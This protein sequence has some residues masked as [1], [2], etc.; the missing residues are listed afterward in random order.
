M[1]F[2]VKK[3]LENLDYSD[4]FRNFA[5]DF[6]RKIART[7][8]ND[9]KKPINNMY[10][11]SIV[12]QLL[13]EQ[14]KSGSD[15]AEY[16]FGDRRHTVRHL[17]K[18]GANPTSELVEKVADFLGVSIDVL[19]GRYNPHKDNEHTIEMMEKLIRSQEAQIRQA[20]EANGLLR[21]K[22]R[23]LQFELDHGSVSSKR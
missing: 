10:S 23:L 1:H 7:S 4:F 9:T 12:D 13:R 22:I 14:K 5:V 20:E 15:L 21:D 11:P 3:Y 17:I 16:V 6:E 18:E 8:K 19:Y 2:F